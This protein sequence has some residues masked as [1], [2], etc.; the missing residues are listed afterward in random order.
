VRLRRASLSHA[1]LEGV[2]LS[3]ADLSR[4]D[5]SHLNLRGAD[6]SDTFL[7]HVNLTNADLRQANLTGANLFNANLS[8]VKVEGAIFKQN[9]GLSAAQGR[10]LEQRG[11]T[12]ELSKLKSRD[13]NVWRNPVPPYPLLPKLPNQSDN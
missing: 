5:L 3:R 7:R 1:N 4:A 11:A 6:L 2:N 10:E 9:A 12:V 8:G 13:R